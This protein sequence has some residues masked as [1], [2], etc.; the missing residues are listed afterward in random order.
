MLGLRGVV[1]DVNRSRL[2]PL[3]TADDA[4]DR[5]TILEAKPGP[6]S[7]GNERAG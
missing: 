6:Q 4:A 3:Y 1:L 2:A 5:R 7:K